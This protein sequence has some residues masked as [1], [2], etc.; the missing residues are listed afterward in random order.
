MRRVYQTTFGPTDGNCF[1][2]CIAT[3]LSMP[4][5]SIPHFCRDYGDRWCRHF[6]EWLNGLGLFAVMMNVPDC[7][8]VDDIVPFG[9]CMVGGDGGRGCKHEVVYSGGV[10][11]HD[12]LPEGKGLVKVDDIIVFSPA[13][14]TAE[15][16]ARIPELMQQTES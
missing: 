9:P 15:S 3:V 11:Y 1:Q 2:A 5:E 16:I 14:W 8:T 6:Q 10:L 12:P 7:M 4:L 13:I